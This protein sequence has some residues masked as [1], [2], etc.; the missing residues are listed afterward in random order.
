M[1]N[2]LKKEPYIYNKL[3]HSL[4]IMLI[5][6]LV[7]TLIITYM[8]QQINKQ[9]IIAN[10]QIVGGLTNLFPDKEEEITSI[11]F[12]DNN[13]N[14]IE[15]GKKSLNK[16]GYTENMNICYNKNIYSKS[17]VVLVCNII[18]VICIF[19]FLLFYFSKNIVYIM[20][21]LE[22][23]SDG[24]DKIMD[25]NY[26]TR[27]STNNE[28]IVNRIG[29]QFNLMARRLELSIE[30]IKKGREQI[31]SIVTDISHQFKTPLSSIKLFNSLMLEDDVDRENQLQ[32]LLRSKEEI[33]K[34]EWLIKS[35]IG[36]SRLEAGMISIKKEKSD[37]KQTIL[38]AINSI[39]LSASEKN[40]SIDIKELISKDINHDSKWTKE[41][42]FNILE[43]AVKYTKNGG[44]ITIRMEQ[45][46]TSVRLII[47]DTG[48]GIPNNEQVNIFNRFYRGKSKEVQKKEGSGVGLYLTKR[49]LE[50]QQFNI[51]LYSIE[52]TGTT[53]SI[54]FFIT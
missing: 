25:R 43:N 2:Y 4:L 52:N 24:I 39:Y 49:I 37:L 36:I 20:K 38:Q 35:L 17:I 22:L 48:I 18:M 26:S 29:N 12:E 9:Q 27:L 40:I 13:T 6:S 54:L 34:L 3:K 28:G 15:Q 47:Q 8:H 33:S 31:K 7:F 50:E 53:F 51:T 45:L 19:L 21:K 46:E 11:F 16:F 32:F 30:E 23:F 42:I 10:Y 5:I 14:Y 41:A 1:L 44:K